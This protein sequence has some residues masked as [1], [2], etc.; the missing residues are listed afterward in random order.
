MPD[1]TVGRYQQVERPFALP[2]CCALC[3]KADD[4][5]YID[6]G[7]Q[8]EFLGAVYI[9]KS[10][11]Q[12]IAGI[13]GYATPEGVVQMLSD[14]RNLTQERDDLKNQVTGLEEILS[15]YQTYLTA[16]GGTG[17][18]VNGVHTSSESSTESDQ[19]LDGTTQA[20][21]TGLEAR[22]NGPAESS[23]VEGLGNLRPIDS[24]GFKFT[25]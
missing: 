18:L 10:C 22:E 16:G 6:T 7:R 25:L 21:E 3:G 15:G 8:I 9:C 20:R 12:Q 24:D 13:V 4:E 17:L 23:S 19:E 1:V 11:I 5:W 14:I 2:G